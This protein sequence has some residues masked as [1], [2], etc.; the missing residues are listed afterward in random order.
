M[1]S[2]ARNRVPLDSSPTAILG[3]MGTSWMDVMCSW[4]L[5]CSFWTRAFVASSF[6]GECGE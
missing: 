1:G 3:A 4:G 5:Y 2:R 6:A